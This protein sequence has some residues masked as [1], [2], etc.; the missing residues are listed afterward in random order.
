MNEIINLFTLNVYKV[1]LQDIDNDLLLKEIGEYSNASNPS[2]HPKNGMANIKS[3]TPTHT[4]YEDKFYPFGKPESEKLLVE[5]TKA[6]NNFTG[7][8]M[9]LDSAWTIALE[10][11]ESVLCHTHKVNTQLYPENY[12]SVS[13]YVTA[14]ENSAD[15]I[16]VTTHCNTIERATPIKIE[17]GMLLIFN[18]FIPHM[19]NRQYSEEK[20]VVVSAN[21]NPK[22][23]N[24]TPSADWSE[25]AR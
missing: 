17:K 21:F 23:P 13:Y 14:P 18:S 7:S 2:S 8:D 19:T 15:L 22:I 9:L 20:R 6:V 5:I 1:F 11:G 3:E 10:K 25:Y 24:Q 4:F 16:F 12:Y